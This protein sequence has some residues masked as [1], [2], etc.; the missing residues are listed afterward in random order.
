MK[1]LIA[2]SSRISLCLLALTIIS[3]ACQKDVSV[4]RGGNTPLQVFL[5]DDQSLVFDNV[6]IEILKIEVKTEDDSTGH[7]IGDDH[8]GGDD[9]G[10]DD[11][12]GNSGDDHGGNNGSGGAGND[13]IGFDDHGGWIALDINP[14]VYDIMTLRNGIDTLIGTGSFPTAHSLKKVRITLGSNNSV[15]LN[16]NEFPLNVKDNNNMVTI[17]LEEAR[18]ML[19]ASGQLTFWLDFD[20]GRSIRQRGNIFEL[21]SSIRAFS[22]EKAGSIEGRVLP[23][24]AQAI[25]YAISGTDT[26]TAK[27]GHEGEFKFVG[28]KP[29]I[30]S[31]FIDATAGN[32]QDVTINGVAVSKNE[33]SHVEPITLHQ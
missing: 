18:M 7:D 8:G 10:D 5:T 30:Y 15:V 12:G 20:A 23:A 22:R 28:L 27:P 3:V 6:F 26:S 1:R 33:D 13:D 24:E 25:V 29:G 19:N 14:G 17:N 11:H 31:L 4:K 2:S 21:R 16:G 9:N 32:Y